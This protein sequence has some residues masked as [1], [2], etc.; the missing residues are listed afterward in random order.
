MGMHRDWSWRGAAPLSTPI[1]ACSGCGHRVRNHRCQYSRAL[2]L[3]TTPPE[4]ALA[5]LGDCG[6]AA[7]GAKGG[8]ATQ[9][10]RDVQWAQMIADATVGLFTHFTVSIP[11][12]TLHSPSPVGGPWS[13]LWPSR[14]TC[15]FALGRCAGINDALLLSLQRQVAQRLSKN[16][17]CHATSFRMRPSLN[18]VPCDSSKRR[19][20]TAPSRCARILPA[21]LLR[22]ANGVREDP[23]FH[24]RRFLAP[25]EKPVTSWRCQPAQPGG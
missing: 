7:A 8:T 3:S 13:A 24:C 18:A 5:R 2:Q 15:I 10:Q 6:R 23:R 16:L 11:A 20:G 17:L 19:R 12:A 21:R 22:R 9:H 14:S 1:K 25:A 4:E